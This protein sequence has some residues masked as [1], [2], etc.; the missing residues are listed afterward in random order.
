MSEEKENWSEKGQKRKKINKSFCSTSKK[1]NKSVK[2][3]LKG[4]LN[5]KK[6]KG[7]RPK[8]KQNKGE[9]PKKGNRK[10]LNISKSSMNLRVS[11]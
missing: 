7:G 10:L 9:R 8:G 4:K 5:I 3:P 2:P 11:T 6:N 1:Y